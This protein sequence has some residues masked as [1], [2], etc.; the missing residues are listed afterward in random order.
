MGRRQWLELTIAASA[1]L[2]MRFAGTTEVSDPP[3]RVLIANVKTGL[4]RQNGAGLCVLLGRGLAM[5]DAVS[6]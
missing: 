4:R 6:L 5:S 3:F 1:F 2:Q